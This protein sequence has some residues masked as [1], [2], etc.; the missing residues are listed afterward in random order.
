MDLIIVL[1]ILKYVKI[2]SQKIMKMEI[3]NSL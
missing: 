2:F 1:F 3:Y